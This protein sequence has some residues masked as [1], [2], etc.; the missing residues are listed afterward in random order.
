[1]TF[2]RNQ[3]FGGRD[4]GRD[5]G[6]EWRDTEWRGWA[7]DPRVSSAEN[8]IGWLLDRG[9]LETVG[10]APDGELLMRLSERVW[11]EPEHPAEPPESSPAAPPRSRSR[12]RRRAS[13]GQKEQPQDG[14]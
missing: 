10:L 13:N 1:M 14:D 6:R 11:T 9:I 2:Y 5:S 12:P 3:R 8:A 7:D 4:G